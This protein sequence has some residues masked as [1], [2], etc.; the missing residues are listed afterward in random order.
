MTFLLSPDGK[1][2]AADY[3]A[4]AL[5]AVAML[6]AVAP[7]KAQGKPSGDQ[8]A[9]TDIGK[10][11][12]VLSNLYQQ[13][14]NAQDKQNAEF[15]SATIQRLWLK[16]GS[17]TVDILMSRAVH[18]VQEKELDLA[19]EILDA[20]VEI[21]PKYTEGWNQRA[22]VHF[23]KRDYE[24][25]LGDLRRVLAIEPRHYRAVN[26]LG[27]IL[28][29]LGEKSAALKA[30]RRALQLNPFLSETKRSIKELRRD[31]EGQGI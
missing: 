18:M 7:V 4:A 19:L 24:D 21:A 16:S 28:Q 12:Q 20:V 11:E 22:T 10:K 15:I 27:L 2:R 8:H 1:Y 9:T 29:E 13:L 17:E 6:C 30:Y 23:L 31:V 14:A 5:I 3:C 25:S 26:G